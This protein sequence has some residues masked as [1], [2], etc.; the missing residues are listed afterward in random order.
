[1]T[2]DEAC[3]KLNDCEYLRLASF[4]RGAYSLDL[5]VELIEAKAQ[6]EIS[7]LPLG[8]ALLEGILGPGSPILPDEGSAH[9]TLIFENYLAVSIINESYDD[10]D[11]A[12]STEW[13]ADKSVKTISSYDKSHFRDYVSAVTFAIDDFP[14]PQ[15]HFEIGCMDHI[16]NVICRDNPIITITTLGEVSAARSG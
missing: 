15:R 3:K 8:S 13:L 1:M 7:R 9:F 16:L 12:S 2:Y 11:G 14:G 6:S 4:G 5:R 10:G